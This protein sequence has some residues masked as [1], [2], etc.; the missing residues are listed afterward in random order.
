MF[1]F[2]CV[3]FYILVIYSSNPIPILPLLL[4]FPYS[5]G[6][7]IYLALGIVIPAIAKNS[8]G[9]VASISYCSAVSLFLKLFACFCQQ[10]LIGERFSSFV[11]IRQLVNINSDFMRAVRVILSDP[12]LSIA[13]VS[14]LVGG[15]DWPTSVTAGLLRVNVLPVAIGTLPVV[16]LI[17]PSIISGTLLYISSQ[18]DDDGS[19]KYPWAISGKRFSRVC[20]RDLLQ[21]VCSLITFHTKIVAALCVAVVVGIQFCFTIS[22]AIFIERSM[23]TRKVSQLHKSIFLSCVFSNSSYKSNL[24]FYTCRNGFIGRNRSFTHR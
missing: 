17:V 12:G 13:K 7:P 24:H 11:V 16:V 8:W 4:Y 22:A 6:A 3:C 9:N 1:L 14:I 18:V 10:K 2:A 15:P 23:T 5:K 20:Q 21:S 19:N